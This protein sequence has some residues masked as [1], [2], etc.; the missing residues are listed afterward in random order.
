MS[1]SPSVFKTV[2]ISFVMVL[3]AGCS[4][5][6]TP[7]LYDITAPQIDSGAHGT[8]R[9][10][11]IPLPQTIS[12]LDSERVVV[13]T[14][15]LELAYFPDAQWADRLPRLIQ[16]RL[17]QAFESSGRVR[18]IGV[19]GQGLSIDVQIISELRQFDVVIS[20]GRAKAQIELFVQLI[21]DRNGR[22]IASQKFIQKC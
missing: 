13:R 17:V 19:P 8:T 21:N 16:A 20:N 15:G 4:S 10:L 7:A 3:L 11:L 5:G 6:V 9:Q 18:A 14:D 22:V 12:A 1:F 2:L